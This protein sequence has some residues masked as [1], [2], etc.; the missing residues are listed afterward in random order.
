MGHAYGSP[1]WLQSQSARVVSSADAEAMGEDNVSF[2]L[3][4]MFCTS[5]RH[6]CSG[7]SIDSSVQ[8]DVEEVVGDLD[9]DNME[10]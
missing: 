8:Q 4:F 5:N 6:L 3:F 7:K 9:F 10:D 2:L 1:Q